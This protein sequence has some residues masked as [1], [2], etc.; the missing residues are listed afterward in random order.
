M[1]KLN[2][3]TSTKEHELIKKYLEENVSEVLANKINNGTDYIKNNSH[4]INKKDLKGF[5]KFAN[6]EARKAAEKGANC[7]CIEDNVVFG[8]AIH[9][10]EEDSIVGTLYNLDG[11]EYKEKASSKPNHEIKKVEVKKPEK[12]P[13]LFDFMITPTKQE[14]VEDEITPDYIEE[15]PHADIFDDDIPYIEPTKPKEIVIENITIDTETGE[16]LENNDELFNKLN[17][18]LNGNLIKE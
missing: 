7:A 10:F 6:D 2:L 8:W 12:Q 13:D 15:D 1:I 3:E 18:L 5:M 4:L 17:S 9:Y 14:E 16:V 11:T